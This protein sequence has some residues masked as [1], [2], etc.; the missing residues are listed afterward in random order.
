MKY[1]PLGPTGLQISEIGF[2]CGDNAGLIVRA[3][4]E[5]RR[6]AVDRALGLGIN[7][8]DTSPDYGKGLSETNLGQALR[9]AGARPIITTKV[10]IMPDQV[11]DIAGAVVRS[12]EGSLQRLGMDFVDIVQIHNPPAARRNPEVAGWMPVSAEDM[13]GPRGAL[14]GLQRVQRE[15]KA[16]FLGFACEHAE[17]IAV[18]QLLDSGYVQ[19]INV[20]YD[21]LNP[22]AGDAAAARAPPRLRLRPDPS[23]SRRP[24]DRRRGHPT[25]GWGIPHR[26]RDKRRDASPPGRRSA[27]PEPRDVPGNGGPGPFVGLPLARGPAQLIPSRGAFHPHEPERYDGVGGL[28]RDR[29][30]GGDGG[31][32]GR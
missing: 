1:R 14:E 2:G 32:F 15:G 3:T 29:P 4:P 13:L 27:L 25:P 17:A 22:T 8:F 20:W 5:E 24:R 31:V 12:V 30:D 23:T 7:Y 16:R 9:E 26:R 18:Y 28:F 21:L 19:T 6:R 10:E 11:D